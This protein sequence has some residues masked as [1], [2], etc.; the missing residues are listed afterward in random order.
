M[1]T[2]FMA[3]CFWILV[4]V[5]LNV[6]QRAVALDGKDCS[7]SPENRCDFIC[8]CKD[9]SDEQ[10]CGYLGPKFVCDFEHEGKC[11]WTAKPAEGAYMW[12]RQRR[13]K[14]LPDSGPSSDYTTGTSTG[15]FMAVTAVTSDAPQTA[16]L[17]SPTI[18]HSSPTCR[19]RLRY[20]IWDSGHTGMGET[21]LWGS[22]RQTD[23]EQAVVWRPESSSFRGWREDVIYLGRITGPFNM[24]L[25]SR[26]S[27]GKQG[28]VA[29]DHM[30]FLDC[31]LPVPSESGKC[32]G[33]FVQCKRDGCVEEYKVCDGTDD[34]G[35]GTDEENCEQN[36]SC[37]FEDGLCWWDLRSMASLKWTWT[38]QMNISLSEPLKGPGR[39]HSSNTASGRFL[40]VTKPN[41]TASDWTT[42]QSP[43]LAPTNE[44]HPCRMV[45]YTH[46]FG[47]VSGGLSV[48]VAERQFY[49]VW[50]RGGALGD[51]WVKAEVEFVVNS[52][53]QILFVAAIR[54]QPYGG[55]AVDDIVLS[56]GCI[57]S[58]E[59][60]PQAG[61]PKPPDHPCTKDSSKICDFHEDCT[62]GEDEDQCGD[63]S[64]A[65][66]SSGWTDTSIGS[67]AWDLKVVNTI[68]KEEFLFVTAAPGQQLSEAQTRTPLLGPSGPVCTLQFSYSLTGTNPHIGE[69]AVY[70]VDSVMG[71]QPVLWDFA[72]RTNETT[73]TWRKEEVYVG[74]RD[75]RFQL[76]FRARAKDLSS[77]ALIA[78]KDV[79]FVDCSPMFIPSGDISCNFEVNMCGWYQDQTDNYNWKLHSGMD[80]TVQDGR[81]LV[82]D[83]WDPSLR[84]LS[85]RLLSIRQTSKTEH[86][87]SFFYKLY[88]PNTGALSVKLLF[89][90]GS[91]ELLWM[92]SGAHGNVWHEGHCP[93][94]PQLSAFQ[95]VFEATRSGFDGQLALDDVA[96]VEGQCSLPTMCSFESQTC[97]YTSSG[98]ARWVHQNWASSKNGPTT[99]HSLETENGFYMLAHSS[100]D[101]LPEGS[102]TTLTSPVR[103]GLSHTECV[104]FWYHTGGDKPGTLSVYVKPS[105]G[106][107]ILLFSS[108][109]TQG[110]AWRHAQGNVENHGD[111]QLQFEVK[112]GG[113]GSSSF[114]AIDDVTYSTHSCPPKDSVCDFENGLCSWSNTQNPSLDWLD[115][116]VTSAQTEMFYNT[117]PYDRTSNTEGHFLVLPNSD[118]DTATHNALLLSPHLSSTKGT[119]L[120]FWVY[121]PTIH[122]TKLTVWRRSEETKQELLTLNEGDRNWKYFSVD[123]TSESEYQIV[124]EGFK[125]EKGVLALDDLRY[126]VG[127]N[128]AGQ[129]TDQSSSSSANTG[130]IVASIVVVI[131][132]LVIL[133]VLLVLYR[134]N[135]QSSIMQSSGGS[136]VSCSGFGN[137]MYDSGD[138]APLEEVSESTGA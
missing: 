31:A 132:L 105:N 106:D 115:W 119:C 68:S 53:F 74:A 120:S 130:T 62:N 11:G 72:G 30:E 60:M 27:E 94:P 93:V 124:L 9:C 123:I 28:D 118:R 96:F 1:K 34:C 89:A 13:G 22:V 52:T 81:S 121:Q 21:P 59:S 75:H 23:G 117:P 14:T 49:P 20:F 43:P 133:A 84:G 77:S 51:L 134:K 104:H 71:T 36:N 73:G 35:D 32:T 108:S 122:D 114:I 38:D 87:L 135:K 70:V 85:G 40:Y 12:Q 3:A 137:D 64:Y 88:G 102:V 86:C 126:T 78:V 55:I 125:G 42:F 82:V 107:R 50:R 79:H 97:G 61:Y 39:D 113:G 83:M 95:L 4:C 29:I 17:E 100:V 33:G 16:I 112:G 92:R 15:W 138:T 69:L 26:R 131:V 101:I 46:Q 7:S 91:E 47:R 6:C 57:L 48:L 116:D 129:K 56:P 90:D 111:W 136:H 110:Q 18:K 24:Q 67:Q 80:H 44:T 103:K 109:V 76:E 10:D 19:L 99:D 2:G 41:F 58:N 25:H 66:G 98:R 8:D 5:L 54:D 127:V 65:K 128:C 63:F 37:N 45:M